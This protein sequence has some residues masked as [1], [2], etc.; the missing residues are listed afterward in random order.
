M[1]GGHEDVSKTCL[2][3]GTMTERNDD[4]FVMAFRVDQGY[5]DILSSEKSCSTITW[6]H[7]KHSFVIKLRLIFNVLRE[8][9]TSGLLFQH[10][11]I[12]I[13]L[14]DTPHLPLDCSEPKAAKRPQLT[15]VFCFAFVAGEVIFAV[16]LS[17]FIVMYWDID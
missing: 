3:N 2:Q 15:L 13:Q 4:R 7:L 10:S 8:A 9:I 12:S 17:V 14:N 16:A 5:L 11:C 1:F 6:C